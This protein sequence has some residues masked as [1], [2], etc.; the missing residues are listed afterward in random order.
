MKSSNYTSSRFKQSLFFFCAAALFT[1][2]AFADTLDRGNGIEERDIQ[3]LREWINTKRQVTVKEK[4]GSLA[5]SGEVRTEMQAAYEKANGVKQRGASSPLG[6]PH[7][8]FD[9][10]V[11]LMFDYR[12]ETTWAS[13]KL[14]F[15]NDAGIFNGSLNK[16]KLERAFFG[17]RLINYDSL[18]FDIEPGRRRINSFIDT[19]VQGTSFFD[20]VLFRYDQGFENIANF[21]IHA[22]P[23]VINERRYQF[24]YLGEIGMLDIGDSGLYAKYSL[25]DWDTKN[26]HNPRENQRFQFIVNQFLLGYKF[27]PKSFNKLIV[28]YAAG[29]LNPVAERLR[30]TGRK[31]A[32]WGAYAGFSIGELRKKGDWA[33]DT[34]YQLLAPQVVPDFDEGGLGIGNA[35][36]GGFYTTNINGTGAPTTR[37][38]AA[39]SSNYRGFNITLEYLFTNNLVLFQSFT[40]SQTLYKSIG[41]NRRYDQYELEFN[42]AF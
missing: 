9:V 13:A 25:I 10:E 30:I 36:G 8:T 22:G 32:N 29:L 11:N 39:G 15:D 14:E 16:L 2:N 21:Y 4:G 31:R 17:V 3:A 38:T 5:I 20:G 24:G 33:L 28:L 19:K 35:P 12:A 41:P 6:I 7:E 18:T 40:S 26:L 34:S 23:F 37:A 42:Y 27:L 1:S